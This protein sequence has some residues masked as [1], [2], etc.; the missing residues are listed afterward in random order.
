VEFLL[1]EIFIVMREQLPMI[2]KSL[3]YSCILYYVIKANANAEFINYNILN[4][5]R[6]CFQNCRTCPIL[7]SS[8]DKMKETIYV[9][10]I[11]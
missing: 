8:S 5:K 1:R 4:N 2:I 10:S 6:V 7:V 11:L 9:Q 3:K